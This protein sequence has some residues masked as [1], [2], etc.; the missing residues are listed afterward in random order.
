M[1]NQTIL[2]TRS[3]EEQRRKREKS[4][5][6][7]VRIYRRTLLSLYGLDHVDLSLP[8]LVKCPSDPKN[9]EKSNAKGEK[10]LFYD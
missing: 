10:I 8:A 1:T 5:Y 3:H 7:P 2:V 9:L 6:Q 4:E